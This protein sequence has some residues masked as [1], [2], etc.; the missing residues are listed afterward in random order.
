MTV[1]VLPKGED[2]DAISKKVESIE[3]VISASASK[4][5]DSGAYLYEITAKRDV[6]AEL[7]RALVEN[8]QDVI[9]LDRTER[10]LESIFNQY[11]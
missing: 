11:G 8:G 10:E 3:D 1:T 5:K 6:R 7:C 4:V 9:G 2:I